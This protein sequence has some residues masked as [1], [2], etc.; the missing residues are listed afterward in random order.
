MFG[1]QFKVI[2]VQDETVNM[3]IM[4]NINKGEKRILELV[5]ACVSHEMRNPINSILATNLKLKDIAREL[6][7]L[8]RM[9]QGPVATQISQ[10]VAEVA[11]MS[12]IQ[13]CSTKLLNLY[14]ADLLCLSQIEN[15]SFSKNDSHFSL[16]TAVEEVIEI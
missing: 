6:K 13:E 1:N 14:V 12:R 10:Q 7:G 5:N 15:N 16:R 3:T 4:F 2:T 8:V 11:V 9:I